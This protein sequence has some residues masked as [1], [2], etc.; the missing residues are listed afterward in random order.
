MAYRIR[1]DK[2]FSF[3]AP[4]LALKFVGAP[5]P[6]TYVYAGPHWFDPA[7]RQACPR[8]VGWPWKELQVLSSL[9]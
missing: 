6:L 3:P 1:T 8:I 7:W 5:D 2:P 4:P 9:F